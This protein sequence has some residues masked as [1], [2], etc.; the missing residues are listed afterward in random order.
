MANETMLA[1]GAFRFSIDTAA[2]QQLER[3]SSYK[4]EEVERFGQAPLM[5]YCGYDSETI[6]LQGTILPEYKGGL[7][8]MSQ[9]RVQASLGI[10]LPLVSGT[11]NYFGLW[12][13]ESINEAQEVFWANGTPRK[14]N[15]QINLKKYA[16]VTLKIGPFNV[17]ASGLLGSLQ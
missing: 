1:L 9:M 3:Q 17:S 13:I 14:I 4:W 7:G 5:Q 15:F 12:V 10:S 6:S 8:Q 2:Y 11:G 16:E